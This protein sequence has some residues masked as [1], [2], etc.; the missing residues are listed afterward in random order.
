MYGF[1][2]IG[3]ALVGPM[4]RA[5]V[6]NLYPIEERTRAL[7]WLTTGVT[8]SYIIGAPI[9]G[10]LAEMGDWRTPFLFFCLPILLIAIA[11]AFGGLP[12]TRVISNENSS[13]FSD[14]TGIFYER[15][16]VACLL[17]TILTSMAWQSIGFYSTSFYREVFDIPA[18]VAAT[19]ITIGSLCTTL[20]IQASGWLVSKYGRKTVSVVMGLVSGLCIIGFLLMQSLIVSLFI[21]FVAGIFGGVAWNSVASL[22]LEQGAEQKGLI[23]SLYSASMNLGLAFGSA[24]GGL[25]IILFGYEFMGVFL[26]LMQIISVIIIFQFTT[27]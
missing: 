26:G 20:G 3:I 9:I 14:Y 4:S 5:L 13:F 6:G 21:R 23:M 22:T 1:A 8:F 10:F 24:I 17:A 19:F 11:M 27:D 7:A 12:E 2:G 16:A 15:S 25:M 18:N